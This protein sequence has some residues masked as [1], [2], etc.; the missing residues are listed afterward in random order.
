MPLDAGGRARWLDDTVAET[1]VARE[2]AERLLDR[3][4]TTARMIAAHEAASPDLRAI[5][6]APDYSSAEIDWI[7][8]NE[9]VHHLED[10][11]L[12]R[13]LM[14]ITGQLTRDGL[15]EIGEIAA[16]VLGWDEA[17]V[18]DE[19]D[20]VVRTLAERHGVHL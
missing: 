5:D 8:A 4:G 6:G 7:V 13:T 12:R 20:A 10:I 2:R 15:A 16:G 14:A 18:Q 3:Y 9:R 19:A 17:R 11:V 1:G